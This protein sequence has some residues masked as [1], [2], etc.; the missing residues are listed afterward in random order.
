MGPH[1]DV[2]PVNNFL[3]YAYFSGNV[4]C[5]SAPELEKTRV[6]YYAYVKATFTIK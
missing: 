4:N 1:W 6:A 5:V 2:Y 3:Y